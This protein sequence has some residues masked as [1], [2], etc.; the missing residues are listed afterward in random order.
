MRARFQSDPG[1]R[2]HM[3]L[4]ARAHRPG[5]LSPGVLL[6]GEFTYPAQTIVQRISRWLTKRASL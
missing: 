2:Q 3:I 4:A 5:A 6:A 1:A